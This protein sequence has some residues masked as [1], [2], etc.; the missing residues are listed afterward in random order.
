MP[1]EI[2]SRDERLTRVFEAWW[3][4][5]RAGIPIPEWPG[6]IIGGRDQ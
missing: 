1:D 6:E 5:L 4:F 3:V 2:E